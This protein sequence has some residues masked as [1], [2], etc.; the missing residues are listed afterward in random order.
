MKKTIDFG[1]IRFALTFITLNVKS[2]E[3]T[4]YRI[5]SLTWVDTG[6]RVTIKE[7]EDMP[8]LFDA[9]ETY[10]EAILPDVAND[11]KPSIPAPTDYHYRTYE[12][13]VVDR[14]EQSEHYIRPKA[15]RDGNFCS[16]CEGVGSIE[17]GDGDFVNCDKCG[18]TGEFMVEPGFVEQCDECDTP[19][20]DDRKRTAQNFDPFSARSHTAYWNGDISLISTTF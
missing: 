14:Y 18:D 19:M 15:K 4:S 3:E 16:H 11:R 9:F 12:D 10:L 20:K 8:S 7:T 2:W 17:V 5:D 1:L 6:E 13:M